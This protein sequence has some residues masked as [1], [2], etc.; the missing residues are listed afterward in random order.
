MKKGVA[1]GR[2]QCAGSRGPLIL[3]LEVSIIIA[4]YS[5]HELGAADAGLLIEGLNSDDEVRA[6][7]DHHVCH[8]VQSL[9]VHLDAVDFDNLVLDG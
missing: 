3:R 7:R 9:A 8:L 2:L 5:G 4:S 6:V 1:L